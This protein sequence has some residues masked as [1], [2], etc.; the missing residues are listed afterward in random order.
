MQIPVHHGAIQ[1]SAMLPSGVAAGAASRPIAAPLAS[2]SSGSSSSS[3]MSEATITAN[4]FLE[5]LVTEMK[6]QDPTANTDP[7]EYINQLVQ[8]NSL[9]QLIQINQDL[10][11][12]STADSTG[13]VSAVPGNLS[14]NISSHSNIAA[15]A[16]QVADAL[17]RKPG[18]PAPST[19][20]PSE[21]Q[22]PSHLLQN[23]GLQ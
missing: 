16:H 11:G 22:F 8:V 13:D 20:S 15:A 17:D 9:E 12:S 1:H 3:S 21:S 5:L 14:A 6:N 4:D 23:I 10:G 18:L 2:S 19:P 7:N